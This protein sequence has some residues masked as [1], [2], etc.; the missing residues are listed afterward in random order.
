MNEL[1][2]RT[3]GTGSGGG[4]VAAHLGLVL[5]VSCDR[6]EFSDSV[7]ESAVVLVSTKS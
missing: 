2:T 3:I 1:A 4:E 6:T 7:S 5:H